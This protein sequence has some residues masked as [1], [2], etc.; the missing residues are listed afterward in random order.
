[1]LPFLKGLYFTPYL[2]VSINRTSFHAMS[3]SV[4]VGAHVFPIII[5]TMTVLEAYTNQAQKLN[6]VAL[7]RSA[8]EKYAYGLLQTYPRPAQCNRSRNR[9]SASTKTPSS[10]QVLDRLRCCCL[11]PKKAMVPIRAI[12]WKQGYLESLGNCGLWVVK[13]CWRSQMGEILGE[14]SWASGWVQRA[15]S[16]LFGGVGPWHGRRDPACLGHA[17]AGREGKLREPAAGLHAARLQGPAC[18]EDFKL[19]TEP[20]KTL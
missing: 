17:A 5:Q 12:R 15:G 11:P 20:C 14:R 2:C 3:R 16:R 13:G 7:C 10:R 19:D 8:P 1:M 18:T 9:S 4:Q 6:M